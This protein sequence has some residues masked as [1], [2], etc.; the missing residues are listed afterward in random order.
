MTDEQEEEEMSNAG[1]DHA[2]RRVSQA[3]AAAKPENK[4]RSV[5]RPGKGNRSDWKREV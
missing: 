2:E 5:K 4:A 1:R 3:R